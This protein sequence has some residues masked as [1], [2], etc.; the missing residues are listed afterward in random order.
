M[1]FQRLR[2][3]NDMGQLVGTF[4][5]TFGNLFAQNTEDFLRVTK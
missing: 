5:E 3:F 2:E 4:V 1:F